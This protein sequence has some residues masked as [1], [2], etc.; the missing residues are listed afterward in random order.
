LCE[1]VE[2]SLALVSSLAQS[3]GITLSTD[4]PEDSLEVP[5]D[6]MK[7]KQV[8]LN[9]L[10]NA[11][12]FTPAGGQVTTKVAFIQDRAE[13]TVTDTGCGIA[14]A[15]LERVTLPFVQ[16]ETALS[17]KFAGSGLG[18]AIARE[19]CTLHAGRLDIESVEGEGTTVRISLPR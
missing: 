5:G 3:G 4:L 17:R 19:L 18:L 7:L 16:V 9:I 12:K 15:D 2:A 6:F 13:I 10:S 8:L 14:E 1:L 11:I